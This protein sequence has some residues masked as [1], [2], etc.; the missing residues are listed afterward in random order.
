MK[1]RCSPR[2]ETS[3]NRTQTW[4]KASAHTPQETP[5]G[6]CSTHLFPPS[7]PLALSHSHLPSETQQA[8]A[9]NE[10]IKISKLIL[11]FLFWGKK[12]GFPLHTAKN[13][14]YARWT[15]K[16]GFPKKWV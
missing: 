11:L 14:P 10:R 3:C 12:N 7:P 4:Q 1:V 13:L 5:K 15:K 9:R 2:A 8:I 6:S 16:T